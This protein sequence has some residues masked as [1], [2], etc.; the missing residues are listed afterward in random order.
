MR[1]STGS[2]PLISSV[3]REEIESVLR[4]EMSLST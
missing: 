3:L 2:V 4:K 1:L